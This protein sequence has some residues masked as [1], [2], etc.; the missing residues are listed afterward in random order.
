MK[1]WQGVY[2]DYSICMAI[3]IRIRKPVRNNKINLHDTTITLGHEPEG[4]VFN[5]ENRI[6]LNSECYDFYTLMH[7]L[8][9]C[10]KGLKKSSRSYL[11]RQNAVYT[12]DHVLLR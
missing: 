1:R 6:A 5:A 10:Y 7:A 8:I 3:Y 12:A 4:I 11:Q 9:Y 2:S